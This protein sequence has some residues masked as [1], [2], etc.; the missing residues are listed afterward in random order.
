MANERL[1]LQIDTK[2]TGSAEVQALS[3]A[4]NKV[5]S[6]SEKAGKSGSQFSSFPSAIK[7]FVRDPLGSAEQSIT[8][9]VSSFGVV[10]IA[11]AG[12]IAGLSALGTAA[13]AASAQVGSYAEQISNMAERTGLSTT[14]VQ[15]FSGAAK[16]AGVEVGALTAAMKSL[17]TGLADGS[18]EGKKQKLALRELGIQAEDALHRIRPAGELIPEIFR[19]LGS[20]P[21]GF[22]RDF[23]AKTLLGKGGLELIPL[24]GHMDELT[25]AVRRTGVVMSSEGVAAAA[26]YDDALDVLGLKWDA[27]KHKLAEKVIGVVEIVLPGTID[28]KAKLGKGDVA[29]AIAGMFLDKGGALGMAHE[30]GLLGLVPGTVTS[31]GAGAQGGGDAA[32]VQP[33]DYAS[34]EA[35][36]QVVKAMLGKR[37]AKDLLKDA[38]AKLDITPKPELGKYANAE[39]AKAA[40]EKW[41]AATAAVKEA[42]IAVKIFEKA[43]AQYVAYLEKSASLRRGGEGFL[44]FQGTDGRVIVTGSEQAS[45]NGAFGRKG[46]PSLY[47]T[48]EYNPFLADNRSTDLT[49]GLQPNGTFVTGAED[50]WQRD[51]EE[52]GKRQNAVFLSGWTEKVGRDNQIRL[53]GLK[54][55]LDYTSQIV[56]LRAGPG[57]ELAA[58]LKINDLRLTAAE[59][60][61]E[62]TNDLVAL[63][64]QRT[65]LAYER[66][67]AIEQKRQKDVQ[68]FRQE[69]GSIFDALASRQPGALSNVLKSNVLSIGRTVTENAAQQY[70]QPTLEKVIPHFGKLFQGTPFGPDPLKSSTDLNTTATIANTAAL[71]GLKTLAGS[72]SGGGGGLVS[73]GGFYSGTDADGLPIRSTNTS[74]FPGSGTSAF[75]NFGSGAGSVLSGYGLSVATDPGFNTATRIGAAAGLAGAAAAGGYGI[76]SGL[77]Q[78]G[79]GGDL[80][81]AGSAAGLAGGLVSNVSHLLNAAGPL[82]SAIPV[83][84]S[85]AA[86]AL[87]LIGSLFNGPQR[88]ANQI[89]QE[90]ESNKYQAPTALNVTQSSSGTFASFDARGNIRTSNFSPFPNVTNPSSWEQTH[91]LF[92]GPPTWYDVPGRLNSRFGPAVQAPPPAPIIIHAMDAQSFA[93][94]AHR[95]SH[96]IGDAAATALQNAHARLSSAVQYVAGH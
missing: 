76:Y 25:D 49:P 61:F 40:V 16:I 38:Q 2:T 12:A 44:S 65:K 62:I 18:E 74:L 42:E 69:V 3:D 89:S 33:T 93:D 43:E 72:P 51:S 41:N 47:R 86:M 10:G 91:G 19:K 57:G 48:G 96:V 37:T 79:V 68:E 27:L 31:G 78:G 13:L 58:A 56:E 29:L 8:S 4:L 73:G 21:A 14:Q 7:S 32:A 17:S 52:L 50:P 23:L 82:L 94:F 80:K 88:R 81:A 90:L 71:N 67:V 64:D 28:P 36:N 70:L 5:V 95:N 35:A 55:E 92:G 83:V 26:K 24:I 54:N 11:A 59:K 63:E 46:P 87:P 34:I 1:T 45:A 9:F 20:L 15:E 60:E 85:I 53:D 30:A 77:K 6:I 22:D 66:S 84:G 39:Q 75:S